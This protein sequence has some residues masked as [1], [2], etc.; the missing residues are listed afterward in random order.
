MVLIFIVGLN[1]IVDKGLVLN[2]KMVSDFEI[3]Q[4]QAREKV[5]HN[6]EKNLY[7]NFSEQNPKYGFDIIPYNIT[8]IN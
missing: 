1:K 7:Y 5:E 2:Q 4:V 6:L 8:C 3:I